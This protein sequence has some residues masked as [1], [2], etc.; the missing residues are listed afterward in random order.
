MQIMSLRQEASKL[1]AQ[2]QQFQ[3]CIV[4][5]QSDVEMNQKHLD[6]FIDDTSSVIWEG[7]L[8]NALEEVK[9]EE[10]YI[11]ETLAKLESQKEEIDEDRID[12][13][14]K[15][16]QIKEEELE[17]LV[18]SYRREL[19]QLKRDLEQVSDSLEKMVQEEKS[20]R[21]VSFIDKK[22]IEDA[23]KAIDEIHEDMDKLRKEL[24]HSR[25]EEQEVANELKES[26]LSL[27]HTQTIN[28]RY[29]GA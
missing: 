25:K 26:S 1:E 24:E 3:K 27:V 28:Y 2:L 10:N 18:Q 22:A 20:Q 12:L 21:E 7:H 9:E 29:K 11:M 5:A 16:H 15:L 14:Q 6:A 13:K 8:K 17:C 19:S 23:Q 4:F